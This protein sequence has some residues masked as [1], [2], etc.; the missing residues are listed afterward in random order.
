MKVVDK[1]YAH[2]CDKVLTEG[3]KYINERRGVERTQ[4]SSHTFR[5]EFK[6]GFPLIELKK[7]PFKSVM[8]ELIWFQA[9][10]INLLPIISDFIPFINSDIWST[11]PLKSL[12]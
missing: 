6:D 9:E 5:H 1:N 7:V 3:H 8:A 12:H 11:S 4:I 10:T 2:I